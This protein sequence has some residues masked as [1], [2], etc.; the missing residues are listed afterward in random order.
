MTTTLSEQALALCHEI[1][2]LPAGEQQTKCSVAAS[3]LLSALSERMQTFAHPTHDEI[4][5][6]RD[7]FRRELDKN[8]HNSSGSPST[9]AHHVALHAFVE[10][11]N[12]KL[13]EAPK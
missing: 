2:K 5:A 10:A 9:D 1:E 11:R 6:Y 12:K 8:M 7:L 13:P 4:G 3:A